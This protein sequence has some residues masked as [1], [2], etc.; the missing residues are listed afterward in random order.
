MKPIIKVLS[1]VFLLC[2]ASC[3]EELSVTTFNNQVE[4][5]VPQTK[6]GNYRNIEDEILDL[7]TDELAEDYYVNLWALANATDALCLENGAT[8]DATN[9]FSYKL[10]SINIVD[11]NDNPIPF[12]SMSNADKVAFFQDLIQTETE[13]LAERL[14]DIPDYIDNVYAEDLAMACVIDEFDIEVPGSEPEL[15]GGQGYGKNHHRRPRVGLRSF[16]DDNEVTPDEEDEIL[17]TLI[18]T[19]VYFINRTPIGVNISFTIDNWLADNSVPSNTVLNEWR[20]YARRGD[21]VLSLPIHD[22]PWSYGNHNN[23]N[24]IGHAGVFTETI[25]NDTGLTDD[26][27]VEA[28]KGEGVVRQKATTWTLRH[29][30]LGLRDVKRKWIWQGTSRHLET[31]HTPIS[32]PG[33]LATIAETQLGKDYVTNAE[34]PIAKKLVPTRYTCTTLVWWA[35]KSCYNID[36]S[37]W[38]SPL[39]SPSAIYLSPYVY[40]RKTVTAQL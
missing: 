22:V 1:F 26:V 3:T 27:T 35:A 17:T 24:K 14:E 10:A 31:I 19:L 8:Y 39:V 4:S 30:V 15:A 38:F 36:I 23:N 9:P 12:F 34:F 25:T 13:E 21:I 5:L 29:Y 6:S 33:L 16:E 37:Y 20:G 2:L 18:D 28:W 7:S 32:N 11:E 40:V